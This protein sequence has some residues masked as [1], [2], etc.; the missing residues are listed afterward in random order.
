MLLYSMANENVWHVDGRA[1]LTASKT[2]GLIAVHLNHLPS[3]MILVRCDRQLMPTK[4][5]SSA[6]CLLERALTQRVVTLVLRHRET[7]IN[8]I[9]LVCCSSKRFGAVDRELQREQY[10]SDDEQSKEIILREGQ[11]LELRFR[12]NVLPK[13]TAR[14]PNA[15]AFNTYYPFYFETNVAEIDTYSQHIAPQFY[16]F[17][18]IFCKQKVLSTMSKDTEKKKQQHA[19]VSASSLVPSTKTKQDWHE[20]EIC[21]AEL[22]IRLP[23]DNDAM[24]TPIAKTPVTLT[25][26]GKRE[27]NDGVRHLSLGR[28]S[29]ILSPEVF[30]DIASGL[31]SSERRRLAYRLGMTQVRIEAI[32]HDYPADASYQILLAWYKRVSRSADNV[33]IL[34]QA[35]RS[36]H[37]LDLVQTLQSA[38]DERRRKQPVSAQDGTSSSRQDENI[39]TFTLVL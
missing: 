11:L 27:T 9:C 38:K 12:G 36:L 16:G 32:E 2:P 13:E 24:P 28:L 34:M 5:I 7:N 1:R 26:D 30:R 33:A 8:E 14:K 20:T 10:S 29:G 17:A 23:K 22:V 35:L 3:R 31:S 39:S 15:F 4:N 6:I 25:N 37:R 21:L 19:E 18:Q